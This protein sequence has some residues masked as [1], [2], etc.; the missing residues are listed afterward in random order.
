MLEKVVVFICAFVLLQSCKQ[1]AK[2]IIVD[3]SSKS[4][5]TSRIKSLIDN[6]NDSKNKEIIVV[7]HRADWRNAPENSLQAIQNCI[8]IGVDMVEI[9]IRV[10]KDDELVIIHDRTLDRTT[11][12]KGLVRDWTLD[13]LKTLYLKDGL[14]VLTSHQ[15]P[16]LEE[17]L[18]TTKDKILVNLDKSYDIFDKC[19]QTAL[20]TGTQDQIIIKGVK[21]RQEVEDEFGVY[22]DKVAFMPVV[23]LPDNKA[24]SIVDDYLE[25]RLPVAFEFTV[26]Q[27]TISLISYFDDIRAKGASVWVNALWPKH[28]GGHDDEK[29][30]IN[31]SVYDWY[32]DNH[33]DIIQTD[34]PKLLL[35]Y[36]RSKGLHN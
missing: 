12:G 36:L 9:D 8:E 25:H 19:Y 5:Y 33:V 32:I 22:L 2:K 23:R 18:L 29:A 3:S 6:L 7:A 27:D 21:T 30:A 1:E 28:N 14:G 16:T 11:N 10:T 24:R 26:P 35:D 4:E 31:L 34:R 20:K 17:A 13:S 15:I